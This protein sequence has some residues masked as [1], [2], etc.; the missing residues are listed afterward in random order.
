MACFL[1]QYFRTQD[2]VVVGNTA[3]RNPAW[4]PAN[5]SHL[6]NP[7]TS[8]AVTAIAGN[9]KSLLTSSWSLALHG[10]RRQGRHRGV[11]NRRSVQ[12]MIVEKARIR[13]GRLCSWGKRY[14]VSSFTA[15]CLACFFLHM[16]HPSK[17]SSASAWPE[18]LRNESKSNGSSQ[19][20]SDDPIP[21]G[22]GSLIG[23]EKGRW[24]FCGV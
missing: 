22:Y 20:M 10:R 7:G 5:I 1:F 14:C 19:L 13:S 8:N 4:I 18:K 21:E 3:A 12:C 23:S 6:S 24:G 15:L 16:T 17:P 11:C 2:L 9:R